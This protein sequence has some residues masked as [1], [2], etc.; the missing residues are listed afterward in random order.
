M[1]HL[2][3]H[4]LTPYHFTPLSFP[5]MMHG[6]GHKKC[7]SDNFFKLIVFIS[8]KKTEENSGVEG[9][10]FRRNRADQAT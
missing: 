6:H 2:A 10:E 9:I 4:I 1:I 5:P 8:F 3:P 7:A